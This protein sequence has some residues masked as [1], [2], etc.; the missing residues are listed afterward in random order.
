MEPLLHYL[1]GPAA[2]RRHIHPLL[3]AHYQRDTSVLLRRDIDPLSEYIQFRS[4]FNPQD[5]ARAATSVPKPRRVL[6]GNRDAVTRFLPAGAQPKVSIIIAC[7][8]SKFRNLEVCINSIRSQDYANWELL[9]VGDSASDATGSPSVEEY[10]RQD[11]RIKVV[12]PERDLNI[13][14]ATNA[15]VAVS[16]GTYIALVD[17]EDVIT[18]DALS[19]MLSRMLNTG[20]DVGYSDQTSR[21]GAIDRPLY[22]PGWSP[23]LFWSV[24][25]I[26]RL[27]MIRREIANRVGLFNKNYDVCHE[28]E[29][30]LRLSEHTKKIIH[31]PR[32]LYHRLSVGSSTATSSN[33]KR[34]REQVRALNAHFHRCGYRVAAKIDDRKP[35]CLSIR[36]FARKQTVL[37]DV[38]MQGAT[39][40]PAAAEAAK[41]LLRST[42]AR[43]ASVELVT[44]SNSAVSHFAKGSAPFVLFMCYAIVVTK[45]QWLDHL[46]IYAEQTD[47]AFVA[48]HLH[49]SDGRAVVG[50]LIVHQRLGL[51]PAHEGPCDCDDS[52]TDLIN[53]D[54]EVSAVSG[55]FALVNRDMLARLGGLSPQFTTLH[56]AVGEASYR[57]TLSGITNISVAGRYVELPAT[58][59]FDDLR[60]A[61]DQ[62]LFIEAHRESLKC[63]DRYFNDSNF[64]HAANLRAL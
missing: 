64:A 16:C 21:S 46:L 60:V 38:I 33:A 54:R 47:T 63:G 12:M 41:A 28:F 27:L 40:Q 4:Q 6:F 42:N 9:V 1:L 31:V 39:T 57:A 15:G 37:I 22:K 43:L 36:P 35:R 20:A 14:D 24:N 32:I 44:C 55:A 45:P 5:L 53:Y 49:T 10:Q 25:F 48:P 52:Y 7:N 34:S 61:I 23:T 18:P 51:I 29:F 30:I 17:P 26:G 11:N 13:A 19:V 56:G 50:G 8:K 3:D 59:T 2:S 62:Q 58:F